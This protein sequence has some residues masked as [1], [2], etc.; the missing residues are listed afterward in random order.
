MF[1]SRHAVKDWGHTAIRDLRTGVQAV[2]HSGGSD[3]T[4]FSVKHT[5]ISE[6]T[7]QHYS[8]LDD[9]LHHLAIPYPMA[10]S[11]KKRPLKRET[12]LARELEA[13]RAAVAA[14]QGE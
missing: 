4:V 11:K 8:T 7:K 2:P 10:P 12:E 3:I 1:T 13:Q 9:H 14:L 5:L 6:L